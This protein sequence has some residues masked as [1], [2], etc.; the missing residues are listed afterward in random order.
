MKN[1]FKYEFKKNLPFIIIVSSIFV[2]IL[3]IY[4]FNSDFVFQRYEYINGEATGKMIDVARNSPI[5]MITTFIYILVFVTIIKNFSFKMKKTAVDVN[6]QLPIKKQKLY[7][8]K[9]LV[10]IL[11][12]LIPFTLCILISS[13]IISFKPNIFDMKYLF[14]YY[15][16]EIPYFIIMYTIVA[17]AFIKGNTIIDGIINV[18][19]YIAVSLLIPA[20]LSVI[21]AIGREAYWTGF[22]FTYFSLVSP[23]GCIS[24][25][26]NDLFTVYMFNEAAAVE[27]TVSLIIYLFIGVAA[28]ILFYLNEDKAEDVAQISN[29]WF[30]YKVL[31]PT[32][33]FLLS[34][35]LMTEVDVLYLLVFILIGSYIGYVIYRRHFKITKYDI[36]AIASTLCTGAIF[37]LILYSLF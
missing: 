11:E 36:I 31:L 19:M 21:S 4:L 37:G 5:P 22:D 27:Y 8:I 6:Y 9:Y 3:S 34:A 28:F 30:S 15:L 23:L 35:S 29:S 7:L 14:L 2:I 32:L 24:S 17:F 26:F 1:Y 12:V 10:G 16:T 20:T 25:E 18:C 33:T 13:I